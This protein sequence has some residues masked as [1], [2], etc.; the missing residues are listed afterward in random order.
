MATALPVVAPAH[1]PQPAGVAWPTRGWPAGDPEPAVD[2]LVARAFEDPSLGE[3]YAVVVVHHGRLVAER[4]GGALPSFTSP[5]TPVTAT[6]PLLSWSM[7]KSVLHAAVG[8]LVDAG[9]LDPDAPAPVAAWRGDDPRRG[10][11]LRH[12]LQMRDGLRWVEEYVDAATSDTIEMLFGAGR[13]DVAGY[14]AAKP[15][16]HPPGTRFNYSSGTSNIVAGVLGDVVGR[17]E[18]TAAFLRDRLFGPLG[19]DDATVTL[20]DAGTFVASSFVSCTA[21]SMARFATLYL[22]GGTWDGAP[23]LS[24]AWTE[25]AQV[26]ASR[27]ETASDPTYYAHHWW[28]DG[29]GVYWASGYEGQRAVVAPAADAVVVRYGRTPAERYPALRAWCDATVAALG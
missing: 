10:I 6:T 5:P 26:P 13:A 17:G 20:D 11:T 22:R 12:L 16:A 8:L 28:L 21:R 15:L 27:D 29:A 23:L 18:A 4:Y 1:A 24:R 9:A 2:A 19:M 7:A 25:S 14:A 3:T